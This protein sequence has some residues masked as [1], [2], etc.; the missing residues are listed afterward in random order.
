MMKFE[1][2]LEPGK[3]GSLEVRNRVIKAPCQTRFASRDGTVN[4]R[5]LR[6]YREAARG[7]VGLV[8][9]EHTHI[10]RDASPRSLCQLGIY[11]DACISGLASLADVI[12]Q[13]NVRAALQIT[14]AGRQG[15]GPS[16]VAP[17]RIPWEESFEE[18]G[19]IPKELETEEILGIVEAFGD[20]SLRA[21]QAGF[22]MIEIHGAHGYLTTNFLSTHTNKRTDWYGGSIENKMRFPLEVVKKVKS[23]VGREF[24]VG[25]R[26]S[27]V[28][29]EIDGV[30]IEESREFAKK[31][32]MAGIDVIHVSAGNH[33]VT[34]RE[35][36]PMY[37]PPASKAHLAEEIKKVVRVPVIASG[38]ITTPELAE[39]ILKTGKADFVS[40]GRPLLADPS[41]VKKIEEG[42]PEDIAP[43]IRCMACTERSGTKTGVTCTVNVSLGRD[44]EFSRIERASTLKQVVVV[45]GGP[46][47]MEA[48]RVAALKGY[49]VTLY[50]KD[51]TLGG[52]MKEI[53]IPDF[54]WDIRGLVTYYVNQL[55][56][57][58][59]EVVC[60]EV[61]AETIPRLG[62]D[63]MILATGSIPSRP[64]VAGVEKS[65]V[66]T[67]LDVLRGKEV[68]GEVIV[69]GGGSA[70]C[71]IALYLAEQK[72][73][74]KIIEML[75]EF[76]AD[77]DRGSRRALLE[78][79]K[80][81]DVEIYSGLK[82][83]EITEEG[84]VAIDEHERRKDFAGETVVL[85][86]GME[87]NNGLTKAL[88]QKGIKFLAVGDCVK[89]RKIY[90]AIYEGH[91][92]ARNL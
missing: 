9:V 56:K 90:D 79:L 11:D 73:R 75:N 45:G 78:R 50:E 83:E 49:R 15:L 80:K 13:F 89:P 38:S 82:L 46:S 8:I 84:I 88:M 14:H 59:V 43:C 85:A 77:T 63:T 2:L 51:S 35:I 24:P 27:A 61:T 91:L 12:K 5:L 19:I 22:D 3:I 68:K 60:Q 16:I 81:Q 72:K 33:H 47:G 7:G 30:T 10:D 66:L 31:L 55:E 18:N 39:E 92:A 42:R 87:A 6:Y 44:E 57:L 21:K 67:A 28:E 71:E 41:F 53:S 52:L 26:I 62:F 70:G 37:H 36:E 23:R 4:S 69:V 29:Y 65:S 48:A 76:A 86:L 58:G 32:E 40:L 25:M 17:S 74:V 20:A 54:K 1:R 64:K 34:D